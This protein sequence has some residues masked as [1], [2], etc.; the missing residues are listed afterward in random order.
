MDLHPSYYAKKFYVVLHPYHH[1]Q[2]S[3][4]VTLAY[5]AIEE[6][7]LEPRSVANRPVKLSDGSWKPSALADIK[8]R[9]KKA[10]IDV[11]EAL[12]WTVR[13]SPTRIEKS[14][15][16]P[17]GTKQSWSRELVRD[18]AVSI[19]DA[20]VAASW[21]RS[22]CT[23]HRYAEETR[24]ISMY[25]VHNV[26]FLARRLLLENVGLWKELLAGDDTA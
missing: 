14:R 16:A 3:T 2:M 8:G 18:K 5:S 11:G 12:A 22:R 21:L 4:A 10:K 20:L 24:S 25:D 23:T 15:R 26:Q 13:N 7:Q 19:Q 6:L 9:L 17:H 1:V